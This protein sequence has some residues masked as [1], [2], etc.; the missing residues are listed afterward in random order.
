MF[1]IN[2]V[3]CLP[4]AFLNQACFLCSSEV[5]WYKPTRDFAICRTVHMEAGGTYSLAVLLEDA[6]GNPV[7]AVDSH[8]VLNVAV[9]GEDGSSLEVIVL[10]PR[11]KRQ[12]IPKP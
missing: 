12:A 3:P 4:V 9:V 1:L 2:S 11:Q 7:M 6:F 10:E 5:S 8:G